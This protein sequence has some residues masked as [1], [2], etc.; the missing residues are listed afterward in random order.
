[1]KKQRPMK[2]RPASGNTPSS[3]LTAE[4]AA[5]PA[6]E[7]EAASRERGEKQLAP[8]PFDFKSKHIPDPGD[9]RSIKSMRFCRKSRRRRVSPNRPPPR[10]NRH[11]EYRAA[12]K[13][14]Q[15]L[16]TAKA[17]ID[18]LLGLIDA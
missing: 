11:K 6:H 5:A 4:E 16:I 12:Q 13:D 10:K 17:N 3:E 9:C 14:I 15:E 8:A 18:H 1:M 7:G 2:L